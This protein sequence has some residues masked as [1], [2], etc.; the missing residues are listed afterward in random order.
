MANEEI[1]FSVNMDSPIAVYVQVE[2][3]IQFAIAAGQYKP[4][5]KLP[6]VR[7]MSETLGVNPNTVTKAYRDLE[8]LRLVNSRRGVGVTIA[9]SAPKLCRQNAQGMA[10][11]H[12]HD[13]VAECVM[14]GVSGS[15]IRAVVAE[16]IK[17]GALPYVPTQKRP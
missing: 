10:K 5:D 1:Q 8:L 4:G 3:Q 14:S 16:A 11:A 15:D 9:A 2:N 7:D 12:L 6:S 13:A 17:S